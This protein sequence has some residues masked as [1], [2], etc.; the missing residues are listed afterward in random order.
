MLASTS[1]HPARGGTIPILVLLRHESK[2]RSCKSLP[3]R[4]GPGQRGGVGEGGELG[5]L[6]PSAVPAGQVERHHEDRHA[7]QEGEISV[8]AKR[9]PNHE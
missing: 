9:I 2:P 4:H 7:D 8:G 3:S 1:K 5:D 6:P